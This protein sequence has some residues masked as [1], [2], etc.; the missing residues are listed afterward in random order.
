M[1][2]LLSWKFFAFAAALEAFAVYG[3][4][5]AAR[6]MAQHRARTGSP[7]GQALSWRLV[8]YAIFVGGPVF[9]AIPCL[10]QRLDIALATPAI[11]G[12]LA[13][14]TVDILMGGGF[15]IAAGSSVKPTQ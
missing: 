11:Y 2:F 8:G 6:A 10:L 3:L 4:V 12:L 15:L 14:G 9:L 5:A 1:D 7:P 13:M